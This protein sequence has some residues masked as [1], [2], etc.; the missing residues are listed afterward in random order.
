MFGIPG[1]VF[2]F[3]V[4]TAVA[5]YGAVI[6]AIYLR[7]GGSGLRRQIPQLGLLALLLAAGSIGVP[8]V[9]Q[10]L[11]DRAGLVLGSAA[12]GLN[13][14]ARSRRRRA[15]AGAPPPASPPALRMLIAVWVVIM[16]V[17]LA[18]LLFLSVRS[19]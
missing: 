18:V 2:L 16:V 9:Y 12:L 14:V 8:L 19:A 15:A 10:W 6:G 3:A 5:T 11:G 7:A 17:N 13:F 1:P 4:V